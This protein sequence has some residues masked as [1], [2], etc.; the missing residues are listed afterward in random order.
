MKTMKTFYIIIMVAALSSNLY[1]TTLQDSVR[2]PFWPIGYTP[3]K[4]VSDQPIE[5]PEPV[6]EKP[7]PPPPPKPVTVDEWKM[8]RK[9][10]KINGTT[11]SNKK[12]AQGT[13][14]TSIAYINGS[15]YTSGDKIKCTHKDVD[16]IWRVGEIKNNL[17]D[18]KQESAT[19]HTNTLAKGVSKTS[20]PR[21][22]KSFENNTGEKP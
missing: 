20:K 11:L 8:A 5:E 21:K 15:D 13:K 12:T 14:R 22:Q 3:P 16:F 6:E 18:I 1:S 7:E 19:R 2:D 9:L 4:P 17:V 10:L